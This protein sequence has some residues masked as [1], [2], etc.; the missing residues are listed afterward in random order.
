MHRP[1]NRRR[2][3][4]ERFAEW[5]SQHMRGPNKYLPPNSVRDRA[6]R[7]GVTHPAWDMVLAGNTQGAMQALLETNHVT[8]AHVDAHVR[9]LNEYTQPEDLA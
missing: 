9:W 4:N 1:L 5:E 3:Y 8:Q 7:A 2:S 6:R